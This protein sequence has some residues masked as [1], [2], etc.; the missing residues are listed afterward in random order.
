VEYSRPDAYPPKCDPKSLPIAYVVLVEQVSARGDREADRCGSWA[1]LRYELHLREC[2]PP[3]G[4]RTWTQ[5]KTTRAAAMRAAL[6]GDGGLSGTLGHTCRWL[7]DIIN[8]ESRGS[9][10]AEGEETMRTAC[11]F[12]WLVETEDELY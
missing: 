12:E 2:A 9:D 4:S 1:Y 7:G 8:P 11:R 5:I 6:V 10:L 3:G